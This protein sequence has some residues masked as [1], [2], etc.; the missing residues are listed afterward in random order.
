VDPG[1]LEGVGIRPSILVFKGKVEG[2]GLALSKC[3]IL[4]F[5]TKGLESPISLDLPSRLQ[6]FS[7][8]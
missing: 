6:G 5:P 1:I 7:R 4:K 2:G 8:V 3:I